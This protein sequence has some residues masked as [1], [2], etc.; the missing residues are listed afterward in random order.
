MSVYVYVSI[1]ICGQ[2][3]RLQNCILMSS[4]LLSSLYIPIR[5]VG[6]GDEWLAHSSPVGPALRG[7]GFL[8]A[9]RNSRAVP[10]GGESCR[11][12]CPT[13]GP[14]LA[15][16]SAPPRPAPP[17]AALPSK[18]AGARLPPPHFHSPPPCPLRP[19]LRCNPA[20]RRCHGC[21]GRR[22]AGPRAGCAVSQRR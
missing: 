11:S 22:R 15:P 17:R 19:W 5:G 13:P 4:R 8:A 9:G 6:V 12:R 20:A 16:R 10:G 3:F 1:E 14:P 2:S 18:V 21:Q 7:T